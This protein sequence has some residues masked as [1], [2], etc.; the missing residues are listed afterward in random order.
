MEIPAVMLTKTK[1]RSERTLSCLWRNAG[2]GCG[3]GAGSTYMTSKGTAERRRVKVS[4]QENLNNE[5]C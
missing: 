1:L 3:V 4:C 5:L 2:V